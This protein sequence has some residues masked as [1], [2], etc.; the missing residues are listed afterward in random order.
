MSDGWHAEAKRENG[1]TFHKVGIFLA[2]IVSL[3]GMGA[4][5]TLTAMP[6]PTFTIGLGLGLVVYA[7]VRFLGWC[8]SGFVGPPRAKWFYPW[9][10]N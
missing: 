2:G 6:A 5:W 9:I 10:N 4:M 7:L 3:L 1:R 8:A